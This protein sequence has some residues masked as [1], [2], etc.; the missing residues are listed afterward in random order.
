[1]TAHWQ[2]PTVRVLIVSD[3]RLYRN[4]LA[5]GLGNHD[6]LLVVGTATHPD[7]AVRLAA[8]LLPSV[9]LV[10]HAL[11]GALHAIRF[12]LAA[13]PGVK[14]V[15]LGVLESDENVLACAEAGVAGYVPRE[16][17]LEDLIEAIECASRGELRCSPQIGATLLRLL[18]LRATGSDD[19]P[20]RTRLTS[21]EVEIVRLIEQGLSNKEIAG[22]LGI[23]V[24]TV[25]NHVHNL[26][27]KLRIHRRAEA[28][29]RLHGRF[30]RSTPT[31]PH[32]MRNWVRR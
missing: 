25:K 7:E 4:G 30:G 29:D 21:R 19:L 15:V 23:Q 16:A 13:Q 24:A 18:A 11:P 31:D 22:R 3:V 26:L 2:P 20:S 5:D 27:E 1:V 17:S 12:I 8:E 6:G 9:I 14:V 28:A 10:D 32:P